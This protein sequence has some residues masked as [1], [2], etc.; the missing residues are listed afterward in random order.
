MRRGDGRVSKPG[1]VRAK[2]VFPLLTPQGKRAASE[3]GSLASTEACWILTPLLHHSYSPRTLLECC[4]RGK[5]NSQ[6]AHPYLL[7]DVQ[8][9]PSSCPSFRTQFVNY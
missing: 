1:V 9:P 7:R 8:R 5:R 6:D 3:G 2:C 4:I